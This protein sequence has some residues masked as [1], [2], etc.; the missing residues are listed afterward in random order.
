MNDVIFSLKSFIREGKQG[1]RASHVS[2]H[3]HNCSNK[4]TTDCLEHGH[5]KINSTFN[6]FQFERFFLADIT[7]KPCA[8]PKAC[9]R[10]SLWRSTRST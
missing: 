6:H 7:S 10:T 9:H 2:I 3:A 8:K 1:N 4:C 5:Q